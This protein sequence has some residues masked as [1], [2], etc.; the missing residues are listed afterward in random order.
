[1]VGLGVKRLPT[2]AP[3]RGRALYVPRL[4]TT[5]AGKRPSSIGGICI[6]IIL[7]CGKSSQNCVAAPRAL[8]APLNYLGFRF[9]FFVL[10]GV[11]HRDNQL[12]DA[13]FCVIWNTRN[14]AKAAFR[15]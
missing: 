7:K 2:F 1:L 12:D 4:K 3:S 5:V 11:I 6:T 14:S 13:N 15:S 10:D 9:I 8:P